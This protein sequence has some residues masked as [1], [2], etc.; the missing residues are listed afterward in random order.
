MGD[1]L[2]M[3]TN[4]NG[5]ISDY[6]NCSVILLF[7]LVLEITHK[8]KQKLK[9]NASIATLKESVLSHMKTKARF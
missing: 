6:K 8:Y 5:N 7:R 4:H 9:T 3:A 2:A 1:H